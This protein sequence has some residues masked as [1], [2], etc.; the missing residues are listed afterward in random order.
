MNKRKVVSFFSG[1]IGVTPSVAA[2]GDTSPRDWR[3]WICTF[4][5]QD[6]PCYVSSED[7]PISCGITRP[8]LTNN[9]SLE[10]ALQ[11]EATRL[12]VVLGIVIYRRLVMQQ[13]ST[14][15]HNR[16]MH[17]QVTDDWTKYAGPFPVFQG[18][19]HIVQAMC[20]EHKFVFV[21]QCM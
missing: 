10:T 13:S 17:G 4:N 14:F 19:G 9:G 16:A 15:Q 11:L 12:P 6:F 3:H 2:P 18:G 20:L 21:L 5:C 7:M 8:D 1:K